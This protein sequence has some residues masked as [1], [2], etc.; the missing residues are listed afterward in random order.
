[1]ASLAD[2]D[3]YVRHAGSGL[4][5]CASVA[6]LPRTGNAGGGL[7]TRSASPP[8]LSSNDL[9]T[10]YRPLPAWMLKQGY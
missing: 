1:M 6:D 2:A 8:N 10:P 9:A 5:A 7:I 4:Y 3:A